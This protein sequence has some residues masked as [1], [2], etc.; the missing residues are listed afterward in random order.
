MEAVPQHITPYTSANVNEAAES[1]SF[2]IIKHVNGKDIFPKLPL[3]DRKQIKQYQKH[4]Q[5]KD[6]SKEMPTTM[7]ALQ[8][9]N[10]AVLQR[11]TNSNQE[12][13]QATPENGEVIIESANHDSAI[14][15]GMV[16]TVEQQHQLVTTENQEEAI[17]QNVAIIGTSQKTPQPLLPCP[18][19]CFTC[20]MVQVPQSFPVI[21]SN[22]INACGTA[23]AAGI[24][25]EVP[26][27]SIATS[28]NKS[29][30]QKQG[31]RG[32]DKKERKIRMCLECGRS[33]CRGAKG[34]RK[35][36]NEDPSVSCCEQ[37]KKEKVQECN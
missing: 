1:I 21:N 34:G 6:S 29:G 26:D 9:L 15:D 27:Q 11:E 16:E 18:P 4:Q 3:H 22:I 12:E 31:N 8:V 32:K 33:D 17:P 19:R 14:L 7:K 25:L 5:I 20:T 24:R 37:H 30:N 10:K 23:V 2:T 28:N 36:K 13:G 35:Q